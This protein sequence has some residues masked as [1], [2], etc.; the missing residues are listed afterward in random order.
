MNHWK[1]LLGLNLFAGRKTI[2]GREN[3]GSS[4]AMVLLVKESEQRPF[5]VEIP[6]LVLCPLE[7]GGYYSTSLLHI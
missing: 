3:L 7:V 2:F 1:R 5:Q 4:D 6:E